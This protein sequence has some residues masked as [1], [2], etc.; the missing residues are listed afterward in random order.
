MESDKVS[1]I[2]A[3][4][5][6]ISIHTLRMESDNGNITIDSKEQ[7]SIHTLRMESDGILKKMSL[8]AWIFQSTLSVW[9]VTS[10][11]ENKG[12]T[13]VF[14]STLS[15]WRVTQV[16]TRVNKVIRISIHTLRMESDFLLWRYQYTLYKYFNPHSPY[17][18]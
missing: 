2:K 6:G 1:T 8:T 10:G 16:W 7:I 5:I 12:S 9:R 18:E 13:L 15:V 11:Y 3:F 4:M 14:Q 17:G